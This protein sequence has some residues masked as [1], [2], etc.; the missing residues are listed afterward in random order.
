MFS[1]VRRGRM[2][3]ICLLTLSLVAGGCTGASS[4]AQGPRASTYWQD[5]AC[6]S[7]KFPEAGPPVGWTFCVDKVLLNDDGRLEF[8]VRWR[9]DNLLSGFIDKG[10][11]AG[12]RNM[13]VVDDRGQR[14]D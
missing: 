12:N 5:Q 6:T 8:H 10:S 4:A 7:V 14:Y 9:G 11:D 2:R 13:Y 1:I 3:D